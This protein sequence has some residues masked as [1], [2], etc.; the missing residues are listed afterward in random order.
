MPS[1]FPPGACVVNFSH[2]RHE[3]NVLAITL[4]VV[5]QDRI[6]VFKRT[7]D[8]LLQL[9]GF[10]LRPKNVPSRGYRIAARKGP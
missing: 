6:Y 7:F 9:P 8:S 10:V 2:Q 1:K 4:R 3:V 5:H